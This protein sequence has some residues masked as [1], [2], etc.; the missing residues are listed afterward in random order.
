MSF[1]DSFLN[2]CLSCD[3]SLATDN[4]HS[5]YCSQACR[6]ADI[7]KSGSTNTAWL[8]T[9]TT[10]LYAQAPSSYSSSSSL[11]QSL[12]L[13]TAGFQLPPAIDFAAMRRNAPA[14]EPPSRAD[15][16]PVR[17]SVSSVASSSSTYQPFTSAPVSAEAKAELRRYESLFD[18]TRRRGNRSSWT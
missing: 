15:R 3:G 14:S 4:D 10:P 13:T 9:P 17:T 18:Q 11:S 5:P 16:S 7:E 1:E 6:L 12:P 8:S 2:F